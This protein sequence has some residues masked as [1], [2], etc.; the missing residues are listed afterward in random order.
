[1]ASPNAQ[2]SARRLL[3][4]SCLI[5]YAHAQP[6]REVWTQIVP[7]WS[8]EEQE[9]FFQEFKKIPQS[10]ANLLRESG[11]W[12]D[13]SPK[14]H[15][16]L[17]AYPQDLPEQELVDYS[18][19]M[20]C[21]ATLMWALGMLGGFPQFDEKTDPELLKS[22][23]KEGAARWIESTRLRSGDELKAKRGLAE[24]WHW[25][26]R[27]RQLI[28]EGRPFQGV[29]QSPQFRSYDDI[30]RSF[31]KSL[32]DAG[33]FS[34][35]IGEDFPAKGK[36]YRDLTED[37][38]SVVRSITVE[39]HFALNWLCGHAPGNRWDETPTDT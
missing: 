24:S 5:A 8:K 19:R 30:I 7:T 38:W 12:K 21:A 2:E 34:Q 20:E 4:L 1:M 37:E 18:W 39:R 26:S 6:P 28:V 16:F 33:T 15:T 25:R 11:V 27:T 17:H 14:E 32:K 9:S 22:V 29:G 13:M 10:I 31:A 35:T 3:V 36:A 23:P